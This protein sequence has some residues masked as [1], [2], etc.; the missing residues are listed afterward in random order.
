[1]SGHVHSQKETFTRHSRDTLAEPG[2][3]PAV[4]RVS[5]TTPQMLRSTSEQAVLSD[6]LR[7]DLH[8][9]LQIIRLLARALISQD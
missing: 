8:L 7:W 6:V 4:T 3:T 2:V 1:M 5:P 9:H